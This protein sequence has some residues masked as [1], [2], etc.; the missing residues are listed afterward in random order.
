YGEDA[1]DRVRGRGIAGGGQGSGGRF[2]RQSG[3]QQADLIRAGGV[4]VN[5]FAMAR[6]QYSYADPV[7]AP[8]KRS[9]ANAFR[10]SGYGHREGISVRLRSSPVLLPSHSRSR[11][12][13][14][15]MSGPEA[16]DSLWIPL[17]LASWSGPGPH[18][19]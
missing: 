3:G 17:S 5:C 6:S 1:T 15:R 10:W 18:R 16:E 13:T 14:T 7:S 9:A 8:D 2:Q 12:R 11:E 19:K 4:R